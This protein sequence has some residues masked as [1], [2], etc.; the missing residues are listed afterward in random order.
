M[1]A[2]K[3]DLDHLTIESIKAKVKCWI[4]YHVNDTIAFPKK[5]RRIPNGL[6]GWVPSQHQV[7]AE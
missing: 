1:R 2:T 5:G 3:H 6:V 7:E 4:D